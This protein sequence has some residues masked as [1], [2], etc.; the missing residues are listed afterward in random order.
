L[1]TT[2]RIAPPVAIELG[3]H[4]EDGGVDAGQAVGQVLAAAANAPGVRA[5]ALG[6]EVAEQDADRGW[7]AIDDVANRMPQLIDRVDRLG[8]VLI[9]TG[10]SRPATLR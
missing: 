6:G 5:L 3:E 4:D 2:L 10:A 7:P 9:R 8:A 1:L